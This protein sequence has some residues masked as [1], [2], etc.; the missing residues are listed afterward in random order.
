LLF[1]AFLMLHIYLAVRADTIERH[2]GLSAMIS[3]GVWLRRGSHP[4]DDPNL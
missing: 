3:G 2:G 1:W 4:V